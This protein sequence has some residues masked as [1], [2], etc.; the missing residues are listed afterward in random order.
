[1]IYK[2]FNQVHYLHQLSVLNSSFIIQHGS[3]DIFTK[4]KCFKKIKQILFSILIS[5]FACT[6]NF[7]HW[8]KPTI[9]GFSYLRKAKT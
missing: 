3:L 1:M 9:V 7:L 8:H 6:N 5:I 2:V 4:F